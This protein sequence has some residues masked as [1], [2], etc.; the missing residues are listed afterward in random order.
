MHFKEY[1]CL[2]LNINVYERARQLENGYAKQL[3]EGL[4]KYNNTF[5][6]HSLM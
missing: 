4:F 5:K 6:D 1:P 2:V 3:N